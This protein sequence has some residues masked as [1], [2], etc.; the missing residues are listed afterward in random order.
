MTQR[1]NNRFFNVCSFRLY[2]SRGTPGIAIFPLPDTMS[3]TETIIEF[4]DNMR[5]MIAEHVDL[6]VLYLCPGTTPQQIAEIVGNMMMQCTGKTVQALEGSMKRKTSAELTGGLVAASYIAKL[7][8][9]Q[10]LLCQN[11]IF[12]LGAG[13]NR[14]IFR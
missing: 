10:T 7:R 1:A 2:R 14:F 8:T 6:L 4:S 9:R 11:T 13:T 3:T 5:E 12:S